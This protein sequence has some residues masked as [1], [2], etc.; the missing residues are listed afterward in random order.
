MWVIFVLLYLFAVTISVSIHF[1]ERSWATVH[2]RII[3]DIF[4]KRNVHFQSY[5]DE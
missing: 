3:E 1:R 2:S 5:S 4:R